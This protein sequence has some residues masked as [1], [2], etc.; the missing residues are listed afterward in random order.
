MPDQTN[1]EETSD[2]AEAESQEAQAIPDEP[3]AAPDAEPT[4]DQLESDL[5]DRQAR[6]SAHWRDRA[7]SA[8]ARAERLA[9]REVLRLLG[10]RVSDPEAAMVLDGGNLADL[11]DEDG[12]VDPEAVAELAGRVTD[13]RPYLRIPA[14]H[15]DLGPKQTSPSWGH[16]ADWASLL[17]GR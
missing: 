16:G 6:R 5:T 14:H 4:G 10:E 17:R 9:H 15:M 11:L 1:T 7:T 2:S 8:E 12:D 13:S 3:D